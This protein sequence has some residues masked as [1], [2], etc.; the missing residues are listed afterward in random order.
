MNN[1]DGLL[2]EVMVCT[3]CTLCLALLPLYFAACSEETVDQS[4]HVN[5]CQIEVVIIS[6]EEY[7]ARVSEGEDID[8]AYAVETESG[9]MEIAINQCVESETNEDNDSTVAN[10]V[11]NVGVNEQGEQ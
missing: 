1:K 7:E 10:G 3:V 4:S 6:Q 11:L 5:N 8:V 9:Q 2:G